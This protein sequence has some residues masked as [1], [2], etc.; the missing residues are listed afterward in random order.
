MQTRYEVLA[1]GRPGTDLV[2]GLLPT[3]LSFTTFGDGSYYDFVAG[4]RQL[5]WAVAAV[6]LSIG[7]LAFAIGAVDRAMARRREVVSLQLAGVG[8]EVLRRTQWIEA[9]LPLAAGIVLAVGLGALAGASYLAYG[10]ITADVP[11][12]Q[13]LGLAVTGAAAAVFVAGL[14][15]VAASPRIRP[16]LIRS[17]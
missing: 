12:P 6:V 5:V 13:T 10:G 3:G 2:A 1:R 9:A 15:V 11:W 4:L 17:E 14:T 16:D 7:L 8:P